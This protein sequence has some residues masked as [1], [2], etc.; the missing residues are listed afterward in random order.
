MKT[1]HVII[2]VISFPLPLW[3]QRI[4]AKMRKR[5]SPLLWAV[6]I[7]FAVGCSSEEKAKEEETIRKEMGFVS[8]PDSISHVDFKNKLTE[9]NQFN[10]FTFPYMYM[11]GGVSIGDIN[12]D[13][14]PDIYFTG[15]MVF[16]KLYLNKGNMEFM[17]ITTKAG[18]QGDNRWYTGVNMVDVNNDG[19][20]DIYICASASFPKK[21]NQLFIN[22]GDLTF[23]ERAEEFGLNYPGPSVQSSFFDYDKDGDLDLYLANYPPTKFNSPNMYYEAKMKA[24]ADNETDRLFRNDGTDGFTDVTNEAGV[25]NFG[26]SLS[27]AVTDFNQDGWLD[28]YV[29]NDFISP[30][31]LYINQGD[32]TFKDELKA[33]TK[34]T[35]QFGM[36]TDF[37]DINN[38]GWVDL[39]QLDMMAENNK[40][41]KTNMASMNPELFYD[42]INR[43]LHHQ[44]MRNCLQIN[45][46][47]GT[48]S[49]V[50]ELA[51]V[52]ATDWSWA[53]LLFDMDNDG[54]KDLFISNGTRRSINDKDYMKEIQMKNQRG[55]INM[56]N[57][58]EVLDKMPVF[59]VSNHTYR[60]KGDLTFEKRIKEWG[61]DFEGFTNGVA[62]GDLDA[63]GDLDLVLNNLDAK[64]IIYENQATQSQNSNY[65]QIE[66]EGDASNPFAFGS[67]IVI[68]Y[69]NEE[70]W[71]EIMPSRGFQSSVEPLVHFGLGNIETI[72][73]L[74]VYWPD[75][76][77]SI[78]NEVKTNQRLKLS[79][80]AANLVQDNR[81][82][83]QTK[84]FTNL[85]EQL[86]ITHQHKENEFDDF[87]RQVLLPHKMSEFGPC[88]AVADVNGDALEDFYVGASVGQA[89]SL[90]LQNVRGEFNQINVPDFARDAASEDLDAFFFDADADGDKDLFVAS[91]GNEY[92]EGDPALQDR[93]YINDGKGSFEKANKALPEMKTSNGVV[94]A[95][96]YDDDGDLDLFVG[97][98]HVPG[99][100]PFS[101]KSYLLENNSGVFQDV[102]S[103][104]AKE[105]ERAGMI[106]A[107]VWA[108]INQDNKVDLVVSGEWMP[109]KVFIQEEGKLEE[110]TKEY[111]FEHSTGWWFDL[112]V[113]DMDKDGDL[114]ILGGNLGLNYKYQGTKDEPFQIYAGDF[115]DNGKWDIVL[116]YYNQGKPYPVRGLQCSSEQMP[117]IKKKFKTYNSFGD[118]TIDQVYGEEK[119]KVALRYDAKHFASSYMENKGDGSFA[120]HAL[121]NEAQISC[122]NS[123]LIDDHDKDGN[124]D[125][126]IAGNMHGSEVETP[127]NDAGIG[128]WLKGDGQGTFEP[129]TAR[130]SGFY[131][132]WV[133]NDM[134]TIIVD[135]SEVVLLANNNRNMQAFTWSRNQDQIVHK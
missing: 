81:N 60:N 78:L 72:Q 38:D 59:P 25:R 10:Y 51:G 31:Y 91:G 1:L 109:I 111:G 45:N 100:Y 19:Y 7:V 106:C 131:A 97:G 6:L 22:N 102:I 117:S 21:E 54:W 125:V 13:G 2:V 17:D 101:P 16:N 110:K 57:L 67:K 121:P 55:Q 15:N 26:L 74:E 50:A 75:G 49:D 112:A 20:L 27:T 76:K 105:L 41:Q 135:G 46:G 122:V 107:A 96:D 71:Q 116:S 39:M 120:I 103:A 128:L 29:S 43:G 28:V 94:E 35:A 24:P 36:G 64:A 89:A 9:S 83:T 86:G 92:D 5:H 53:A 42:A 118:A 58:T 61:M 48:F 87:K 108:D 56:Q 65:L 133:V 4:E 88:I 70:Q 8:L 30:D 130:E 127:R 32:G 119:L 95:V 124:L 34:H 104:K 47:N 85:T 40:Q 123:I 82:D 80:A 68:H 44:F 113:E 23:T 11:G 132:P 77:R 79:H 33:Y 93:L 115:D 62:Y 12:N 90:Y 66:L 134:H 99:K 114:D 129:L 18:V 126:L 73:S 37:A 84:V 69:E 52:D 14:L 3:L 98:R 63:D